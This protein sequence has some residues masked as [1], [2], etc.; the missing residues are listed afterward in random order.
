MKNTSVVVTRDIYKLFIP[1][2]FILIPITLMNGNGALP[3]IFLSLISIAFLTNNVLKNNFSLFKN[4]FVLFFF[5]FVISSLISSLMSEFPVYSL[6]NEGSVFY[7]RY[8]FFSL[9]IIYLIDKNKIV[10]TY[11]FY[12]SISCILLFFF[13]SI[14]Q[15]IN[16]ENIIGIKP[17]ALSRITSFMGFEAKLGRYVSFLSSICLILFFY[18]N[19]KK[20]NTFFLIVLIPMSILIMLL[21]GD[22]APLLRYVIFLFFISFFIPSSKISFYSVLGLSLILFIVVISV[23]PSIKGRIISSTI[24][25]ITSTSLAITPYSKHYEE[26]FISAYLMGKSKPFMGHGPNVFEKI[27]DRSEFIVSSRSCSTHPHN[28]Y[29]QLWSENG[30]FGLFFLILFYLYSIKI[31]FI[32]CYQFYQTKTK[33]IDYYLKISPILF[34]LAFL[35]P[36]I[37]NVSFYNNWNNVF[38]YLAIGLMLHFNYDQFVFKK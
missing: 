33:K 26:H 29:F 16:N 38:L 9:A 14:F 35:L 34:I 8:L 22:R 24:N 37:P 36:I 3:D 2:L 18:I 15:Y 5:I 27:C 20:L 31:A 30:F 19:S 6:K 17:P 11:F 7:F 32:R 1:L 23:T 10:I 21:S 13:D 25:Q 12:V 28:F 4:Y